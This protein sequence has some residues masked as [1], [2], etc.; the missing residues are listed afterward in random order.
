M[1]ETKP[2]LRREGGRLPQNAF[3]VQLD[4]DESTLADEISGDVE[5]VQSGLKTQ[6]QSTPQLSEF[7][8]K[9][10]RDQD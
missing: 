4:A 9:V 3:V 2:P 8:R 5:H 1:Q 6:F 7:M 10:L